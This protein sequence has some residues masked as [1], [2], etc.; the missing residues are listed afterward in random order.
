[1]NKKP[2]LTV[3]LLNESKEL[4]D[5]TLSALP[6][7]R[8]RQIRGW[9]SR[10]V[11][12]FSEMKNLPRALR[13][14]LSDKFDIFSSSVTA[15][16]ED[17][18]GTK[19]FQITLD[20]GNKIEAV[21]LRDSEGRK[22]ACLST[23]AGCMRS[24]LFC[25]TGKLGFKRNLMAHEI[26]EQFLQLRAREPGFPSAQISTDA[27]DKNLN[28]T[29]RTLSHIVIMGMGEP[30]LNLPELRKA[31]DYFMSAE[32]M[33]ISKRRIT[34]STAGIAAGIRD[35]A[36]NGPDIRLAFSLFSANQEI[37]DKF[38]PLSLS[39]PLPLIKENLLY[40]QQKQKQRITLELVLLRGINT[41]EEDARRIADFGRG[42][43]CVVNL[44]PWNPVDNILFEGKTLASPSAKEL[45]LFNAS[46]EKH[47]LN[48]T[49]RISKG[50]SV[51]G[52]CG[53]LGSLG[54]T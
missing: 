14:T 41:S 8:L 9:V 48:V 18:D 15:V 46:L 3:L 34:L 24:C 43:D 10:G 23:Q 28:H 42:L 37:R 20:D 49:R 26:I 19:K 13:E 1:M 7:F 38:I 6:S 2:V 17:S 27:S 5:Q 36:D 4:L 52:A 32:G 35:L 31:L 50:R 40:Y 29:P 25:Q 53:Q 16:L 47:K 39:N 21:I 22:T 44:I 11:R 54:D 51:S 33:G 45:A 12:D 30:L